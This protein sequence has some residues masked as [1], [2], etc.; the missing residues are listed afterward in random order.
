MK[1]RGNSMWIL[2][3]DKKDLLE[4]KHVYFN[5]NDSKKLLGVTRLG[6]DYSIGEYETKTQAQ[7]VFRLITLT[8]QKDEKVFQMPTVQEVKEFTEGAVKDEN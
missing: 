5:R 4:I 8:I 6:E 7:L 1:A 3:Q 2:T